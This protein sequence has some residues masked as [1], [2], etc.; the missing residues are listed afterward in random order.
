MSPSAADPRRTRTVIAAIVVAVVVVGLVAV[1]LVRRGSTDGAANAASANTTAIAAGSSSTTSTAAP[2]P[3]SSA[4]APTTPSTA[5]ASA[6]STTTPAVEGPPD[7]SRT[8]PFTT[9][10]MPLVVTVSPTTG[11][12]DGQTVKVHVVPKAGSQ[13]FGVDARLCAGSAHVEYDAQFAPTVAGQCITKPLSAGS[14]AKTSVAVS[15]PYQEADVTFRVGVGT[16]TFATQDGRQASITCGP[17]S[18]CQ[19]VLKLQY[20]NAFGFQSVP[21]T[22]S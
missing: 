19:L 4:D 18:P 8:G 2:S 1:V 10:D 14:D 6:N 16:D 12:K 13:V 5:D 20:P 3:S 21:V 17:S 9:P 7:P 15:P 22:F 11:M